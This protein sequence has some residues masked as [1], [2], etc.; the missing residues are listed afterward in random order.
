M[1]LPAYLCLITKL[2]MHGYTFPL[3]PTSS[4]QSAELN[5][6]ISVHLSKCQ[7][8]VTQLSG[9]ESTVS[10]VHIKYTSLIEDT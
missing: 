5:L 8:D 4:W 9:E 6:G 3:P 1:K 7:Y 2:R 10:A